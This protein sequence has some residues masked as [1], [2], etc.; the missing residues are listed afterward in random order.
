MA[1][2]TSTLTHCAAAS[3]AQANCISSLFSP[4]SFSGRLPANVANLATLSLLFSDPPASI[5]AKND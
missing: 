2:V 4:G 1:S 3:K 5:F